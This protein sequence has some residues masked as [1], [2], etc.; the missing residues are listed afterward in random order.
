[1]TSI[2]WS[3]VRRRPAAEL[4]VGDTWVVPLSM[5]TYWA[6]PDGTVRGDSWHPLA[7]TEWTLVARDGDQ[8]TARADDGREVT[9]L[10]PARAQV[11]RVEQS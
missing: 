9:D 7:G 3:R 6:A 1:M 4:V 10:M 11:L 2:P 5:T 8:V